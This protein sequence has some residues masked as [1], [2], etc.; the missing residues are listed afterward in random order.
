MRASCSR[1]AS[2]RGPWTAS[3]GPLGAA[4]PASRALAH[5]SAVGGTSLGGHKHYDQVAF[6]PGE[7]SE[8]AERV[9]VFDFDISDHRPP[10][11][12]FAI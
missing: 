7:T 3:G 4:A 12:Q 9:D 11:A 10:W 8:F 5:E 1:S 6:F 2:G